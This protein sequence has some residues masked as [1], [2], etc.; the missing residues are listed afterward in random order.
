M[1]IPCV[2]VK[3][4]RYCLLLAVCDKHLI[5]NKSTGRDAAAG[6]NKNIE[7]IFFRAPRIGFRCPTNRKSRAGIFMNLVRLADWKRSKHQT[8]SNESRKYHK[9]S[10]PWDVYCVTDTQKDP[11]EAFFWFSFQ[12]MSP[13]SGFQFVFMLQF[14]STNKTTLQRT[15]S[16]QPLDGDKK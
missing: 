11:W 3:H 9:K 6:N 15:T 1:T 12:K 4:D 5:A 2:C 7:N 8:T 16:P 13:L 14:H 10:D